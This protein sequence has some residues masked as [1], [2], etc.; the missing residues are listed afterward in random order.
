M[1]YSYFDLVVVGYP[2]AC[3]SVATI[4]LPFDSPTN[5]VLISLRLL[6]GEPVEKPSFGPVAKGKYGRV[7]IVTEHDKAIA[8]MTIH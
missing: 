5:G 8:T 2:I 7:L 4:N 6:L 1:A 3:V